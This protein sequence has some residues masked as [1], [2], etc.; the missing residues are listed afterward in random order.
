MMNVLSC[1]CC[2]QST[3]CCHSFDLIILPLFQLFDCT[4]HSPDAKVSLR[5]HTATDCCQHTCAV[6]ATHNDLLINSVQSIAR[7]SWQL[8]CNVA[9]KIKVSCQ[10]AA[11][12]CCNTGASAS[13]SPRSPRDAATQ[14]TISI[15][16]RT[17]ASSSSSSSSIRTLRPTAKALRI[18]KA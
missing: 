10:V 12:P 16:T 1:T 9:S 3:L 7:E 14:S 13:A 6:I 11:G 5:S 4:Q 17:T 2:V 8:G 18:T 15:L